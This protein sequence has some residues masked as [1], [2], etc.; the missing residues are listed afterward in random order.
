MMSGAK[1]PPLTVPMKL[2]S[3]QKRAKAL[4]GSRN[5]I[6]E[7]KFFGQLRYFALCGAVANAGSLHAS[8]DQKEEHCHQKEAQI[9][10]MNKSQVPCTEPNDDKTLL[11]EFHWTST[12]RQVTHF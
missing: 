7:Y 5:A 3:K 10:S 8:R 6:Q 4:A 12:Q 11:G 9:L 1:N 2:L